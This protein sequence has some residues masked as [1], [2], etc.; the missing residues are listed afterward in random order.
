MIRFPPK[1]ILVPMDLSRPSFSA[2]ET[3]K[4]IA[5]KCGA[6]LDV[7]HVEDVGFELP[8]VYPSGVISAMPD[9]QTLKGQFRERCARRLRLAV[10]DCP[11]PAR[12]RALEGRPVATL[13]ELARG[14]ADLVVMGTHGYAGVERAL[15]G[16]VAE[17]VVRRSSVP[18]LAV[19]E[20]SKPRV[21]RILVPYNMTP[22]ADRALRYAL[23]FA[24]GMGARVEAFYVAGRGERDPLA[25]LRRR[26]ER[27]GR[28]ARVELR[29]AKGDPRGQIL[30]RAK[31][32]KFDMIALSAH[33]RPFSGDYVIGSTAERVLRHS[34][35][36]VLAVPSAGVRRW[37]DVQAYAGGAPTHKMSLPV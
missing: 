25:A 7:V 31:T 10:R 37:R 23:G 8:I 35:V 16:S 13:V 14:G 32:G 20:K 24:H 12:V 3:A 19:R 30:L 6:S 26:V 4:R 11:V 21:S 34:P 5:L 17:T 27:L 29:T 18:V 36:P 33:C 2:L 9:L 15:L 28:T 22:H 1:R